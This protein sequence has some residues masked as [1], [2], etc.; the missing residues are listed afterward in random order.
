MA[1][2]F[3]Q[4]LIPCGLQNGALSHIVG[5]SNKDGD[6]VLMADHEEGWKDDYTEWWF[7]FLTQRGTKGISKDVWQMVRA[8]RAEL[9]SVH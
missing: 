4:L 8:S 5:P 7:E 3:W 9:L 2:G 1:Q 6:D